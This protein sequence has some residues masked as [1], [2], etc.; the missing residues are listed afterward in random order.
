MR[1]RSFW[2]GMLWVNLRLYRI[3]D[4]LRDEFLRV[5]LSDKQRAA[6]KQLWK[7]VQEEYNSSSTLG[8]CTSIP[9]C[10]AIQNYLQGHTIID[11]VSKHFNFFF[12][13]SW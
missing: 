9:N 1:Y 2:K 4:A 3:D 5:K 8:P 13:I 7:V 12:L 11:S 6:I 10:S